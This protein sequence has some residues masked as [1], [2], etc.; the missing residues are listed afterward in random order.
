LTLLKIENKG[1]DI[2]GKLVALEYLN[3][4]KSNYQYILF[5]HCAEKYQMYFESLIKNDLRI[6]LIKTLIAQTNV[7]GIFP[8]QLG[9]KNHNVDLYCN[10]MLS[11]AGI[12]DYDI[13]S[14]GNCF[15]CNKCVL[16]HIF[17]NNFILFYNIL[18]ASITF[19]VIS[20]CIYNCPE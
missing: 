12:N 2:G 9:E 3:K 19:D 13:F 4:M 18:N 17:K 5:L 1:Y 14:K 11:F 20:F 6:N 15:I 7:Y 16:A 8:N 10:D